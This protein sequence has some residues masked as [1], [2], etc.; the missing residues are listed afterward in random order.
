MP[1]KRDIVIFNR[2]HDE[3]VLVVRV[4]LK[5]PGTIRSPAHLGISRKTLWQ[6]MKRHGLTKP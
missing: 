6:K 2:S 3:D 1:A 4:H 5:D